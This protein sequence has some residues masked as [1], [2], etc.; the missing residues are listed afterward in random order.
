MDLVART[1]ANGMET[2][3]NLGKVAEFLKSFVW[4]PA[5]GKNAEPQ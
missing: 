4:R 5:H 1:G 2:I 3:T